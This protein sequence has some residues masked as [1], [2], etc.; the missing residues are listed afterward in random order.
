MSINFCKTTW[1]NILEDCHLHTHCLESLKSHVYFM[2]FPQIN[3]I[4]VSYFSPVHISAGEEYCYK[5]VWYETG[6]TI[7]CHAVFKSAG[8]IWTPQISV[9]LPLWI[10]GVTDVYT[11]H[12]FSEWKWGCCGGQGCL[13]LYFPFWCKTKWIPQAVNSQTDWR[14][15]LGWDLTHRFKLSLYFVV[16]KKNFV[17]ALS[18]CDMF[19]YG[20]YFVFTVAKMFLLK[21]IDT[22]WI[23]KIHYVSGKKIIDWLI[24]GLVLWLVGQFSVD[25]KALVIHSCQHIKQKLSFQLKI[26]LKTWILGVEFPLHQM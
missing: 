25:W 12:F 6:K 23:M 5:P 19:L 26:Q 16:L 3:C 15:R 7:Y 17:C 22:V 14:R 18:I 11:E 9:L 2:F 24:T 4:A 1:C 8:H 20:F 10:T 21:L 13:C